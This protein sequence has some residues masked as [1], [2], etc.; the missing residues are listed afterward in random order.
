MKNKPLIS[1]VV[2]TFNSERYITRVLEAILKQDYPRNEIEII[3]VDD[4][5]A[6]DTQRRVR[7]LMER[8]RKVRLFTKPPGGKKGPAG[9]SNFGIQQARGEFIASVDGDAI[10]ASNW[11]R[12]LLP[13]FHD[14]EVGIAAGVI[15]T[16]NPQNVWAAFAGRELEERFLGLKGEEVDSISPCNTIYKK[17][18]FDKAGLF[19]EGFDYY[20]QDVDLCYRARQAGFKILVTKKTGCRH[21]WR[22]GFW[23]WLQQV[24]GTGYGRLAAVARFPQ[25]KTGDPISGWKLIVQIPLALLFLLAGLL[26]LLLGI[27]ILLLLS[28]A[29]ALILLSIQVPTTLR[30]VRRTGD[31]RLLLLPFILFFRA[32]VWS[33]AFLS[34]SGKRARRPS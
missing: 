26:F 2:T 21:Y 10:L 31:R 9:S 25:K 32:L 1:F 7:K 34:Y 12:R 33:G 29:L 3:V 6:D 27:P 11:L 17:E 20:A 14:P 19:D 16:A 22:E 30:I 18:V 5:S 13:Q 8:S 23:G 15:R 4:N 24:Y 28:L